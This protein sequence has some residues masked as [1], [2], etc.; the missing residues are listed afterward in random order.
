MFLVLFW[1]ASF[2]TTPV[3]PLPAV[4]YHLPALPRQRA[5]D[6][7]APSCPQE[8]A[9]NQ[10]RLLPA[11]LQSSRRW[12][13]RW[14]LS[15]KSQFHPKTFIGH[16]LLL[17]FL[18]CSATNEQAEDSIEPSQHHSSPSEPLT[19]VLPLH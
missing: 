19:L 15:G 11:P 5:A 6:P 2:V 3:F 16:F 18:I 8:P 12:G 17:L 9:R 4:G 7:P 14:R 10:S 13:R 1:A